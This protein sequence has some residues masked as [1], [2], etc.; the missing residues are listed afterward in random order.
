VKTKECLGLKTSNLYDDCSWPADGF[1]WI[2]GQGIKG[3]GHIDI[4]GKNGFRV[5]TKERL[6]LELQIWYDDCSLPDDHPLLIF[7]INES[8]AKVTLT[9]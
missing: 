3:Q 5:I 6:G 8:K 9:L 1:Y 2:F 7:G 4:V